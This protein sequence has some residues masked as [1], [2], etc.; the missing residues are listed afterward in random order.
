MNADSDPYFISE[1]L[2]S[3]TRWKMTDREK[4]APGHCYRAPCQDFTDNV[5]KPDL[6]ARLNIRA[7]SLVEIFFQDAPES[8]T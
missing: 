7:C 3:A 5:G 8:D 1:L 6:F 2:L 4:G